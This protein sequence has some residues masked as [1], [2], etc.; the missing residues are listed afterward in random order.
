M[1]RQGGVLGLGNGNQTIIGKGKAQ[2]GGQDYN[3]QTEEGRFRG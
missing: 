3:D 2:C 1:V